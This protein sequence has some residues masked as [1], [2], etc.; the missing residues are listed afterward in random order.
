MYIQFKKRDNEGRVRQRETGRLNKTLA[1]RLRVL[2][3]LLKKV[4]MSG[5]FSGPTV[6]RGVDLAD[7]NTVS[8]CL[9]FGVT[10]TGGRYKKT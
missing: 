7:T 1:G 9:G 8:F 4:D 10:H 5:C 3:V 2:N 6:E